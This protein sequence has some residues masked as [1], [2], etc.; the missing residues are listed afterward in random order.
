MLGRDY[1]IKQIER[2]MWNYVSF[3]GHTF[4]GLLRNNIMNDISLDK[5]CYSKSE[6]KD[7]LAIACANCNEVL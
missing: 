3:Y 1:V 7:I 6:A 5:D 2:I 4:I